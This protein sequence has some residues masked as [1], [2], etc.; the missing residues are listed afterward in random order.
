MPLPRADSVVPSIRMLDE[1]LGRPL[2]NPARGTD[3]FVSCEGCQ[4]LRRGL[5][6]HAAILTVG[7]EEG[8]LIDAV[9]DFA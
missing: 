2:A 1:S 4:S 5:R 3:A 7:L 6:H 9:S 8:K